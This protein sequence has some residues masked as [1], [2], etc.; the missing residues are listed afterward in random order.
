MFPILILSTVRVARFGRGRFKAS[1]IDS[2]Y[3]LMACYRYIDMNPVR[4]GMVEKCEE[5]TWSSFHGNALG[6]P[7]SLITPDPFFPLFS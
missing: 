7:D 2:E 4:A 6:E 5:Y 1:S 3:Y